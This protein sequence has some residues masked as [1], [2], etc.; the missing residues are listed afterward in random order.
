MLCLLVL[1]L[2]LV[3]SGQALALSTTYDF[4]IVKNN[5]VVEKQI[6]FDKPISGNYSLNL[7]EDSEGIS[8][9]LDDQPADYSNTL[10]L[11]EINTIRINYVTQEYLDESNFLLDFRASYDMDNLDISLILPENAVLKTKVQDGTSSSIFPNADLIATD[12]KSIMLKWSFEDIS[13]GN[14]INFFVR[15]KEPKTYEVLYILIL[16]LF[17]VL[18]LY[19]FR[20]SK[21]SKPQ[22]RVIQVDEAAAEQ[23]PQTNEKPEA[24]EESKSS[25]ELHL[26][27]AEQQ[28]INVLKLKEGKCE[29]GT[30]RI[31]T[32]FSKATLSRILKELEDRK[33]VL[34]EKRGKKNLVFLRKD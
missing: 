26:K 15:Y 29:Q 20:V 31:A 6:L 25:F 2:A 16:I 12:G 5:V 8:V 33:V 28:V 11:D 14:N 34:K 21:K 7:P 27:E 4:S 13:K 32:G 10:R 17:L 22:Y 23:K 3:L 9:Y 19:Y 24:K 30:L 18:L 1:V